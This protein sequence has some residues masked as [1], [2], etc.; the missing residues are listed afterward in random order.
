MIKQNFDQPQLLASLSWQVEMGVDEALLDEPSS[1]LSR[2]TL[3]DFIL[4]AK[5]QPVSGSSATAMAPAKSAITEG[6]PKIM[7]GSSNKQRQTTLNSLN[8]LEELRVALDQ[9]HNCPL[10]NTASEMCFADGNAGARLMIIGEA[11]GRDEDRL[12]VPFVGAAGQFIDSMMASIGLDRSDVYLI[13]FLPWRPPGNRS[14]TTEEID[15][16]V[17]FL[18]RHVQLVKPEFILILGGAPAKVILNNGNNILK[19][20]GRWHDINYGDGVSRATMASLHPS[21][22]IR[23]PSQKRLAFAD[24]LCLYQRLSTAASTALASD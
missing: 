2:L 21:Y 13:N 9:L 15:M 12:G 1:E 10:R 19:L 3:E 4:G 20:R 16:L 8:S 23:S 14:P 6:L 24:W 7:R 18:Y 11:P 17:P 5:L 22:L